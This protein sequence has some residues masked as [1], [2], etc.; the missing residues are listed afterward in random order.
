MEPLESHG[1]FC[2]QGAAAS[3]SRPVRI[4]QLSVAYSSWV[5]TVLTQLRVHQRMSANGNQYQ[6]IYF[7]ETN[8]TIKHDSC[9]GSTV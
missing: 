2:M 4:L 7:P 6:M 8:N 1:M 9:Y 3:M 5:I